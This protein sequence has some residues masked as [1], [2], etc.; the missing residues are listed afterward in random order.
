MFV[1]RPS[2]ARRAIRVGAERSP[3]APRADGEGANGLYE[4]SRH[5]A[6]SALTFQPPEVST[7]VI[8]TRLRSRRGPDT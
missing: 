2:D 3:I 1:R 4:G 6:S 7:S 5:R 8:R